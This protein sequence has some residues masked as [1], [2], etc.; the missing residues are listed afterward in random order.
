MKTK[1]FFFAILAIIASSYG[2]PAMNNSSD[3]ITFNGR[4]LH[5]DGK[6]CTSAPAATLQ[7]E[8]E[9]KGF[10]FELEGEARYRFDID[11]K[12]VTYF[13]VTEKA[14]QKLAG[15][16]D[17][18]KHLYRLIKISESNPGNI[19]IPKISIEGAGNFYPPSRKSNRRIEFIGDSFTVGYGNE[20]TNP[21]DGTPFS[22]TDAS[23]GFAFLLADGFKADF[24]INAVSGRGLV[25]N[26]ANIV[27]DW[28]LEKLYELTMPGVA[29]QDPKTPRWNFEEFHPQI[30]VIFVGINDFQG[31]PP[32]A[33]EK[34]FKAAYAKLLDKLRKAHPGV[35]FL[36]LST[37]V[38]PNDNLTPIV[39]SI[40]DAQ[41]AAG[42]ADLEF[43]I[44]YSE[45]T[46]LHGH[47]NLMS[48]QEM[49]RTLRP[50]IGR[51]GKWLSR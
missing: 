1:C 49:T 26:Y 22:K 6:H 13:E 12:P 8:S 25:R 14:T 15:A 44:F 28:T 37:K 33:N 50:I 30:I 48:H 32:Y 3:A 4:W 29:E 43:Q 9:A 27:P 18:Q 23:Q 19:C 2:E 46:A 42:K 41:V 34:D 40:Y 20:G 10:V 17:G 11:G 51:L 5:A 38:W 31:E 21:E 36:L 39:K 35:K 47:P 45:N 24:Q 7:F 16:T